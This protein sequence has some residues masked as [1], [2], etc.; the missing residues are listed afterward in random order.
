M[1]LGVEAGPR[2][3]ELLREL[4]DAQLDERVNDRRSALQL[5]RRLAAEPGR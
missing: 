4:Y 5:A 3:G 1:N 2:L